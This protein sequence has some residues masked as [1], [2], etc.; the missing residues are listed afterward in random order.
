MFHYIL[1]RPYFC[2]R[3]KAE[4]LD[5]SLENLCINPKDSVLPVGFI[6]TLSFPLIFICDLFYVVLFQAKALSRGLLTCLGALVD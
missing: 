3:Y 6:F 2:F 1:R 4:H 5:V